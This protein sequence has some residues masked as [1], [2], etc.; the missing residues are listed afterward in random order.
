MRAKPSDPGEI[1]RHLPW[2]F[3]NSEFPASLGAVVMHTV[4]TAA[5]P[6]LQVV[7][8]PDNSWGVA[9]GIDDP[10]EPGACVATHIWHVLVNDQS[11]LALAS[12][13]PGQVADRRATNEPWVISAFD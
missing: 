12:L 13:A 11:L 6:A 2:P 10:N 3:E 1:F 5:R 7:H 8:M 4:V 9:D